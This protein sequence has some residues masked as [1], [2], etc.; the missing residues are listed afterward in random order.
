MNWTK[1]VIGLALVAAFLLSCTNEWTSNSEPLANVRALVRALGCPLPYD[2]TKTVYFD[3][4]YSVQSPQLLDETPSRRAKVTF[5]DINKIA[6][7][8]FTDR[9]SYVEFTL[10][11]G[12]YRIFIESSF[13][14]PDTISD[15]QI[16]ADTSIVL[17]YIC[18]LRHL[19]G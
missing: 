18:N 5:E 19:P 2:S 10:R 3:D 16:T 14:K 7:T 15:Y 1:L 8:E 4:F 13:G 9:S 17:D 6:R 12:S 11:P